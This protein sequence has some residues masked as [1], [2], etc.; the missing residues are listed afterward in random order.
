MRKEPWVVNSTPESRLKAVMEPYCARNSRHSL[1][2]IIATGYDENGVLKSFDV[3]Y[4]VTEGFQN[5]GYDVLFVRNDKVSD[6]CIRLWS[7]GYD[8]HRVQIN[9]N[10]CAVVGVKKLPMKEQEHPYGRRR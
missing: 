5:D 7:Q 9:P 4:E 2:G 1:E 6:E 10:E 8:V 3:L